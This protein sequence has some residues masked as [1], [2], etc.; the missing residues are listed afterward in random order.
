MILEGID[1]DFYNDPQT[2]I[3]IG[4]K[5]PVLSGK[6]IFPDSAKQYLLGDNCEPIFAS[7][8]YDEHLIG[9][10]GGK[11]FEFS[12]GN[13]ADH[14]KFS[15]STSNG[16]S[17]NEWLNRFMADRKFG[18]LSFISHYNRVPLL[19]DKNGEPVPLDLK[20]EIQDHPGFLWDTRLKE[21]A[22]ATFTP[23]DSVMRKAINITAGDHLDHRLNNSPKFQE[24]MRILNTPVNGLIIPGYNPPSI[25][26]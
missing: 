24:M 19:D 12:F 14:A 7:D 18:G 16:S 20:I 22:A 23:S 13:A 21:M 9:R 6:S 10:H 15:D 4:I 3:I 25:A 1:T 26:G 11:M 8:A 17:A 2:P 5:G